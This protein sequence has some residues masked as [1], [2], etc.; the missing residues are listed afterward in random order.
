MTHHFISPFSTLL[1]SQ[2]MFKS[3]LL[4]GIAHIK[5]CCLLSIV[6]LRVCRMV[7]ASSLPSRLLSVLTPDPKFGLAPAIECAWCLHYLTCWWELK[8]F[9]SKCQ[10]QLYYCY[11]YSVV[12]ICNCST[13]C[14]ILLTVSCLPLSHFKALRITECCW[15]MGPCRSAVPC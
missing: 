10:Q 7:L 5:H 4:W 11:I 8:A 3:F 2:K 14:V 13:N 9:L 12:S 15:L 6:F 1:L